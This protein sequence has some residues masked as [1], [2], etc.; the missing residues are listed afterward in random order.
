MEHQEDS[1]RAPLVSIC[2]V[3]YQH[4]PYI[5]EA[6]EHFLLQKRDFGIEILIHDD[7]STDGTADISIR[8]A[9]RIY[10]ARLI[11]RGRGAGTLR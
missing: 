3:A 8:G 5:R 4:A 11:F 9:L 6:I 10:P 7:A 2:A 1:R